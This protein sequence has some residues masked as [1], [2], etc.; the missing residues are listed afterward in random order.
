MLFN[1]FKKAVEELGV[2]RRRYGDWVLVF[3]GEMFIRFLSG[4]L[5]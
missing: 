2:G 4:G 5:R 3:K 1:E